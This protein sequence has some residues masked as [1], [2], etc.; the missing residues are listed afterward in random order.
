[1]KYT[2]K[3]VATMIRAIG[4]PFAYY[5]FPDDDPNQKAPDPPFICFMY[6]NNDGQFADNSNFANIN[7]LVIELYC[8]TKDFSVEKRVETV[9]MQH[10]FSFGKQETYI[11][12][13]KL[14]EIIYEMEVIIDNG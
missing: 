12:D 14:I 3:E 4:L 13:E 10:G 6:T 9:L 7:R 2:P 11:N 8:D 5:S 1:M